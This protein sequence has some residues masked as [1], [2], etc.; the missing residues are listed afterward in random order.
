[1]KPQRF[2]A[3]VLFTDIVRSTERAEALGDRG[4]RELLDR[5]RAIVRRELSKF[6]G[7]EIGTTGDGFL[8]V[9]ELPDQA[10]WCAWALRDATRR[11]GIEIRCGLHMGEVERQGQDVGG[12]VVHIGA[13]VAAEAAPDEI[14]VSSTLRDT[15][16]G[17]GFGFEDRGW[18]ALKGIAGEWRVYAVTGVPSE[19]RLARPVPWWSGISAHRGVRLSAVVLLAIVAMTGLY[20]RSRTGERGERR[21]E[22]ASAA[23]APSGIAV[24]PFTVRSPGLDLWREGMVDVLSTNLDGLRGVRAIDSRTV[25]ARWSELVT[26]DRVADLRTALE[27]AQRT[28]ARYALLGSV[29]FDGSNLRL[30]ADLYDVESA[31][32]LDRGQVEGSPDSLFQLVDQL[33][34]EVL[35]ALPEDG[36]DAEPQA[37][38]ARLTT[39]SLP[40]L[41]A[42]LEGESLLRR[43]E[44]DGAIAAYEGAI[45]ADST[46][47]FA[48]YHIGLA[49]AWTP[50][51]D[52]RDYFRL[53]GESFQR[54]LRHAGRLPER[55]ALL[56][57]AALAYHTPTQEVT[58][59][60]LLQEATRKYPDDADA[61]FLLGESSSHAG[62]QALVPQGES[63]RALHKA[64]ELDPGFA[65]SY[66]P[67]GEQ[68]FHLPARQ[69]PGGAYDRR[70][71]P[72]RAKRPRQPAKPRRVRASLRGLEPPQRS[73]RG[74]RYAAARR[75]GM[76]G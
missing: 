8:A 12:I 71:S 42:Y 38:L 74:P 43:A 16:A 7:R 4:W 13:R 52:T 47:A 27:V 35:R 75:P 23:A 59:I 41:K 26:S 54:A 22:L 28:G 60:A 40:A 61:W 6:G 51:A 2:L 19:P 30:T 39:T 72:S 62:E 68:C 21:A 5:H 9:F 3:T 55:D 67:S 18:R 14:L 53:R 20:L 45:A 1:M 25:L 76:A 11:L 58:A 31:D 66:P 69:R 57:R 49:Y 73:A 10:I 32:R 44:F 33:T 15:E 46:F 36:E 64:V 48:S 34:I 29:V 63:D 70:L 50:D 56:L 37:N 65:L 24:L 17:S